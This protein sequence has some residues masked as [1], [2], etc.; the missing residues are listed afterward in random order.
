MSEVPAGRPALAPSVVRIA[1]RRR[2]HLEIGLTEAGRDQ[3]AEAASSGSM[4]IATVMR[5]GAG[6]RQIVPRDGASP[7]VDRSLVKAVAWARDLRQ[8]LERD[9]K[10]LDELAREDGCSRPYV[11]SMIRLAYLAPAL[12]S[13]FSTPP[14]RL[15]SLWLI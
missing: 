7:R 14:S 8:R 11:S 2:L 13:P 3:L 4:H 12:L 6:G 1:D 5:P 9:G 15:S 10:S